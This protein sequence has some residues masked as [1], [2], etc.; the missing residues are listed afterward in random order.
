MFNRRAMLYQT[1]HPD[2]RLRH[3]APAPRTAAK[4]RPASHSYLQAHCEPLV[5]LTIAALCGALLYAGVWL[6]KLLG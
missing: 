4:L 3:T 2:S 5:A 1:C 6:I